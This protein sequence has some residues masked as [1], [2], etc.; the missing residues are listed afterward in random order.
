MPGKRAKLIGKT[1]LPPGTEIELRVAERA[2]IG[3][4]DGTSCKVKE[5]GTYSFSFF[6]PRDGL[7]DGLYVAKAMMIASDQSAP[8]KQ[9]IGDKG[10]LMA[11]PLVQNSR[12]ESRVSVSTEFGVGKTPRV[13]HAAKLRKIADE[14]A[15]IQRLTCELLEEL[16]AFKDKSDFRAIGFG[17]AGPYYRWLKSVQNLRGEIPNGPHP[18]PSEIR[19][20]PGYLLGLGLEFK[21][22]D[23]SEFTRTILPELKTAIRFE[24]YLAAKKTKELAS[25]VSASYRAWTDKSGKFKVEA[26]LVERKKR[27]VI[28]KDKTGKSVKVM[29]SR[30]SKVDRDYLEGLDTKKQPMEFGF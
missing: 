13:T 16:L 27:W 2:G 6:G 17:R 26:K 3:F 11:G 29:R 25:R 18:I 8:V 14:T 19:T 24:A 10:Q 21:D 22:I 30:L 1:N 28:L 12:R 15:R 7:E 20:A 5:N 4:K 23:E 9:I